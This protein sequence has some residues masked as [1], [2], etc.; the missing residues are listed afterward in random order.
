MAVPV[1]LT[2]QMLRSSRILAVERHVSI[3]FEAIESI[4]KQ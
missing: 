2:K 3:T 4:R 1:S